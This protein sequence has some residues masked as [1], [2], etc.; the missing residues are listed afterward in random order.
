MD[1]PFLA[2]LSFGDAG[3]GHP[4]QLCCTVGEHLL[5]KISEKNT[6]WFWSKQK[7]IIVPF[8]EPRL[9]ALTILTNNFLSF[10]ERR[11]L[12][13]NCK[14]K[15]QVNTFYSFAYWKMCLKMI[16]CYRSGQGEWAQ[17]DL[18]W[19]QIAVYQDIGTNAID[20]WRHAKRLSPFQL[21]YLERAARRCW[22]LQ[23]F[24]P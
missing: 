16:P 4:F 5:M 23:L 1:F 11:S 6:K 3:E 22:Y 19:A 20:W 7:K 17:M 21:W 8:W 24:R 14:R 13:S 9:L 18:Y 15:R 12:V 10:E 2:L